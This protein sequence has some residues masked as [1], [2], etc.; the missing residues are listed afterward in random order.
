MVPVCKF[1]RLNLYESMFV[2]PIILLSEIVGCP[3]V[4]NTTP[5]SVRCAPPDE[6]IS[7]KTFAVV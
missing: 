7:P 4:L 6:I 5:H 2:E 1:V 3:S